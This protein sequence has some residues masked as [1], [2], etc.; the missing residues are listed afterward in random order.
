MDAIRLRIFLCLVRC[1]V[2]ALLFSDPEVRFFHV[3]LL[4]RVDWFHLQLQAGIDRANARPD[5]PSMKHLCD[6][7]SGNVGNQTL[8]K[9]PASSFAVRP[10]QQRSTWRSRRQTQTDQVSFQVQFYNLTAAKSKMQRRLRCYFHGVFAL[11]RLQTDILWLLLIAVVIRAGRLL[12]HIM[13]LVVLSPYINPEYLSASVITVDFNDKGNEKRERERKKSFFVVRYQMLESA[14]LFPLE[15][16]TFAGLFSHDRRGKVTGNFLLYFFLFFIFFKSRQQMK[17][18]GGSWHLTWAHYGLW[19]IS[20][21]LHLK[22][23][24]LKRSARSRAVGARFMEVFGLLSPRLNQNIGLIQRKTKEKSICVL[25]SE[26]DLGPGSWIL[27]TLM[28]LCFNSM[29][30]QQKRQISY[31]CEQI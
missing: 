1:A 3:G 10:C 4:S 9:T 6:P 26:T 18:E 21:E 5:S 24:T 15:K 17:T 20:L 23:F 28:P 2:F 13:R 27:I 16:K 30:T 14:F 29:L 31:G 25:I 11:Y 19:F 7:I 22:D 8:M 12:E